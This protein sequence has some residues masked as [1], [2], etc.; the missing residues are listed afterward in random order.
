MFKDFFQRNKALG[1]TIVVSMTTTILVILIV[2]GVAGAY[3][4]FNKDVLLERV[5]RTLVEKSDLEEKVAKIQDQISDLDGF[6]H[7]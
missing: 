3:I 6:R 5:K 1:A 4:F 7:F 2:V